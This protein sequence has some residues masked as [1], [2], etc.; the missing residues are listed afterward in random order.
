MKA[1]STVKT[2]FLACV[3]LGV[4][5]TVSGCTGDFGLGTAPDP[6]ARSLVIHADRVTL[7]DLAHV[8]PSLLVVGERGIIGRSDDGGKTWQ[9]KQVP[10][11]RTLTAVA[12]IGEE[13]GVAVGH[14]GTILRTDDGGHTWSVVTVEEAGSDAVLGI[15][16]LKNGHFVAYGAFGMFLV[17]SDQGKT[18]TRQTVVA[19]TFDRHISRVLETTFGAMFLVGETGT[20]AK[21]VDGGETWTELQSPYEGSFFGILEL[22]EGVLLVFGMRGNIFRSTD[23]GKTWAQVPFASDATL[24]GGSI[25]N[26]GRIVLA[27]NRGLLAISSDGGRSFA[28][29]TAPEGTSLSQARLLSDGTLVYVGVMATGRLPAAMT[30][31]SNVG[32]N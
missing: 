11:S 4:A 1:I 21:S 29:S 15:T 23:Q 31:T 2:S 25:A 18:W 20:I 6:T 10:I 9:I 5:L 30:T 28:I 12:F 27:G 24:N 32:S 17:S 22:K 8:G 19:D 16:A 26:D 3:A 14:G 7:L 13:V